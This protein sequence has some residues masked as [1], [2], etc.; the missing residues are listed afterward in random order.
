MIASRRNALRVL[1]VASFVTAGLLGLL[2]T[3]GQAS[4]PTVVGWWYRDVPGSG[5]QPQ[6]AAVTGQSTGAPV[7]ASLAGAAARPPQVPPTTVPP[8]P[9][10]PP[11]PVPTIPP[12]VTVPDPGGNV[13]TPIPVP[14]GGLLVANDST[15]VRGIAAM[16]FD[17]PGAGGG[18][19]SLKLAPGSTPSPSINA[20]PALSDWL[21]GPDQAWSA[22]PAHD[23][24]RM[25][26]SSTL[27]AD[28]TTMTW[29]LPDTFQRTD[30]STYD[31]LLVPVASDG[32]PYQVMFERPGADAFE[33]TSPFPEEVLPPEVPLP[34]DLP[35]PFE[36]FSPD[37]FDFGG[38]DGT[39]PETTP[40]VEPTGP[41]GQTSPLGR[42]ADVLENPTA[43]R[44]AT[45]L[46]VALGAYAFWQSN[47][48][49]QRAPRLL[50]ALSG[51]TNLVVGAV[52]PP[53]VAHQRGIGRFAR[54]RS[55]RPSRL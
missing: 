30:R 14:A 44:I 17:A 20:C 12:D 32:T 16:R 28:G 52:A 18:V 1:A 45:A 10:V 26:V 29:T 48:A 47:Q 15:G 3:S 36:S 5:A 49:E 35:P 9:T 23:C 25:S 41:P 13:P 40:G 33:M 53:A 24:D 19:I 50:G 46:L 22:R 39:V 38:S 27:S 51:P 8:P 7:L 11:L 2:T 43:R 21:P 54:D 34:D 55:E 31:V 4:E 6:G 42:L 37:G